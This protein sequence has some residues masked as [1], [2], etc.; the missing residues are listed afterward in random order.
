MTVLIALPGLWLLWRRRDNIIALD[1]RVKA[2]ATNAA[3]G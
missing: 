1:E 3:N 2:Q